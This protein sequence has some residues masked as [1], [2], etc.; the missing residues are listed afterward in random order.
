MTTRGR[1]HGVQDLGPRK[2]RE[3]VERAEDS[4]SGH[5]RFLGL[6]AVEEGVLGGL[7]GRLAHLAGFGGSDIVFGAVAEGKGAMEH[8]EERVVP[9]PLRVVGVGG[10]PDLGPAQVRCFWVDWG[11]RGWEGWSSSEPVGGWGPLVEE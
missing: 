8:A 1:G 7:G 4:G 3:D 11:S 9:L 2:E 5:P 10:P 6:G